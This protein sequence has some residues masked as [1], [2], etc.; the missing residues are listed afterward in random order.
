M[1][2]A[3]VDR[4]QHIWSRLRQQSHN[5]NHADPVLD[6]DDEQ[7]GAAW[8]VRTK[9]QLAE[10]A[11]A[12]PIGEAVAI[13]GPECEAAPISILLPALTIFGCMVGRRVMQ[14]IGGT[15]HFL[16]LFGMLVGETGEGRKGT[17]NGVAHRLMSLVDRRFMVENTAGGLSSGEG[18][19]G[20]LADPKALPGDT[21]AMRDSRLH[22]AEEE[23]GTVF[24]RMKRDGNSLSGVLRQAWDGRPL[25]T[26]TRKDDGG[27]IAKEPLVSLTMQVTPDELRKGLGDI[28]LTNGFMNRFI[29]AWT[30]QVRLLPFGRP[31]DDDRLSRPVAQLQAVLQQLPATGA[32]EL[33]WTTEATALYGDEIYPNL[34]PL[35]GRLAAM[36]ARGAPIIRRVAAIYCVS[37][38]ARTLSVEDLNA[39][40]AHWNYSL[41][42]TR[43]IYGGS[44]FSALAQRMHDAAERAGDAG[45]TLTALRDEVG[46]H[47]IA[48][49]EW[50][51]AIRE[52]QLSRLVAADRAGTNGRSKTTLRL[53]QRG[54]MGKEATAVTSGG[55]VPLISP[56]REPM[57]SGPT[58]AP[59]LEIEPRRRSDIGPTDLDVAV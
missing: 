24:T 49:A 8:I 52:L 50:D 40:V 6:A 39:A 3:E 14:D 56:L 23:A 34:K 55:L 28:E 54:K 15:H 11:L 44:V 59:L 9:P 53:A 46:G 12:G 41:E 33:G 20:R 26:L 25:S 19:I 37:R 2:D 1:V 42:S 22:I 16:N 27:L 48:K 30:E 43:Y 36:T 38:G 58:P 21:P 51:A 13:C 5:G 31:I 35:S 45:L 10:A 29:V 17:G 18:V 7:L 4:G 32:L 47:K 57:D